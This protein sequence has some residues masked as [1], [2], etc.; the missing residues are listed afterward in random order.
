MKKFMN[1]QEE[2]SLLGHVSMLR[3][4][5]FKYFNKLELIDFLMSFSDRAQRIQVI[6]G[7]ITKK[8]IIEPKFKW[9][10]HK[11]E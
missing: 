8:L 4:I 7:M 6:K 3:D 2:S 5:E 10:E 1:V 11:N 9:K